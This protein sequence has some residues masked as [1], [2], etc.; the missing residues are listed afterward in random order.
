AIETADFAALKTAAIA[1]LTTNQVRALTTDQVVALT[2]AQANALGSG[3]VVMFLQPKVS[4]A[5]SRII[6]AEALARWE[7]PTE[8]LIVPDVFVP[9]F[10]KNGFIVR[11]DEYIWEQACITIRRWR[12]KGY[13]MGAVSVNISRMHFHEARFWKKLV[14]LVEKYQIPPRLLELELTETVFLEN[15]TQLGEAMQALQDYGFHLSMDDFGS[16][17]SSLTMLKNLPLNIIKID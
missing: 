8:G 11:L 5:S 2:T 17:Y 1:G 15:A 6:G 13:R 3:Q 14:A 12:D 10:E 16:G 4:I 9:L 7:H